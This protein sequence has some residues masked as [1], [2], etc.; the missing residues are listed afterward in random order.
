MTE[1]KRNDIKDSLILFFAQMSSFAIIT[2]NYRAVNQANYFWSAFT[3]LI[4]AGISYFVIKK[5][6]KSDNSIWQRIGFAVGSAIGTIVGIF[7]SIY[8]LGK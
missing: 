8:I 2:I 5:I 4:V 6:S 3:D 1:R 7:I